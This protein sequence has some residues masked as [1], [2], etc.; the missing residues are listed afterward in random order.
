MFSTSKRLHF[1]LCR[2]IFAAEV[3]VLLQRGVI[4][5]PHCDNSVDDGGGDDDD[6]VGGDDVDVSN[7]GDDDKRG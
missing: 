7:D 6:A 2:S 5:G 4:E 3:V 1:F